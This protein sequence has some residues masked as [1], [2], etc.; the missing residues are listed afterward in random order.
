[1]NR[2]ALALL[3]GCAATPTD[4]ADPCGGPDA[5]ADCLRPAQSSEYYAEKS[6]S[7]FDTMDYRVQLEEWPPY[8]ETVARWEWPPWL[9]LT[10]YS[11]ETIEATDTLLVLYPSIVEDRDCRGFD[12]H[13]FGRCRVT[14]YYD[15]HGGKPCPIYEE[16]T[17]NDAGEITWIEAWSDLDGMRPMDPDADPWAED[18][19]E[20]RLSARIPGLG[21][22]DGS[23]DLDSEAMTRASAADPVIAD[24]VERARDWTG[25]W[26][27]LY[28]ET[29]ID[30]MW[31]VGCGWDEP[32]G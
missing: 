19:G 22:G 15:D 11:R 32:A 29:D 2:L 28:R 7:Y 3:A 5:T 9:L 6:S 14:F 4:S 1:M 18:I 24:F 16:F 20:A 27:A 23:L 13:P 12:T 17:F 8:G 30:E 10:A 25:T 26:T 21:A 31:R